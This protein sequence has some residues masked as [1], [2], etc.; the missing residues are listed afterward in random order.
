MARKSRIPKTTNEKIRDYDHHQFLLRD[1]LHGLSEDPAHLKLV[2]AELRTLVCL[3]SGTEGLLWRLI[4]ELEVSDEIYLEAALRLKKD[5]P[6]NL[7]VTFA[8]IPLNRPGA[9]PP[10]IAPDWHSLKEIIKEYESVHLSSFQGP[11]IT[12]ERLIKNI[13]EQMGSAHEDEGLEPNIHRLSG[14]FI[15][16]IQPYT[17]VLA[18]DAELVLQV[19]ERLLDQ[20]ED[21]IDYQRAHRKKEFGDT[22]VILRCKRVSDLIGIVPVLTFRSEISE[23]EIR[24]IARTTSFAFQ[25]M[26]RGK[27]VREESVPFARDTDLTLFAVSYSSKL[28][29]I[30][31]FVNGTG[32]APVS[33]DLG[34]LDAR[35]L[36]PQMFHAEM[37]GLV[38]LDW[39]FSYARLLGPG[40]CMA[41]RSV[42]TSSVAESM[43]DDA[44]GV[45][46]PN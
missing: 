32:Q 10:G 15:N 35:E 29:E 46:F 2:A 26:K 44:P 40:H 37:N 1:G 31:V 22:T 12:H 9:A 39:V 24:G 6:I 5:E 17:R 4:K 8:T 25:F 21:F 38:H 27:L 34:W 42:P 13:A 18:F 41:I 30:R 43:R 23:V 33:C 45:G 16:G 7:G 19:G 28:R 20:A 11:I 36:S 14:L 3:S